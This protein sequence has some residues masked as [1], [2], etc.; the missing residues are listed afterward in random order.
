MGQASTVHNVEWVEN[1]FPL[2]YLFRRHIADG[3]GAG[4]F[5]G[6]SGEES[7]LTL[8]DA[9]EEKIKIVAFGVVGM[10]NSGHGTGGDSLAQLV[11]GDPLGVE[12]DLVEQYGSKDAA[13]ES[14]DDA[15]GIR[16]IPVG[17]VKEA[18]NWARA[19]DFRSDERR[20]A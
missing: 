11:L 16:V 17:H 18:V 15:K 20:K 6:G 7:L 2:M 5:R 8:H 13:A 14:A 4:K 3:A 1:N 12:D 9:P 19:A 10:R